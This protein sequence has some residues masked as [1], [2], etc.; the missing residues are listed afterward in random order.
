[1]SAEKAQ[2]AVLITMTKPT[3]KMTEAAHHTGSYK[4][5]VDGRDYP[6]V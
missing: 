3:A 4:W 1:M 5:P 6:K 2:M